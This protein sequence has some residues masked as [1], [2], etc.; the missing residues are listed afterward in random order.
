MKILVVDDEPAVR[1]VIR[2]TLVFGGYEVATAASAEEALLSVLKDDVDLIT[3]D[4]MM[5]GMKGSEFHGVL[6]QEF[7]AGEMGNRCGGKELPPILM[8]TALPQDDG[9]T[10]CRFGESVVGVLRKPFESARLIEIVDDLLQQGLPKAKLL[11]Q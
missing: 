4:Q 3:L 9:V 10:D 5:P 7:G 6:S 2:D 11:P 8:V 1:E